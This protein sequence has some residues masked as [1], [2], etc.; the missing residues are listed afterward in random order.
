[1]FDDY[2]IEEA[3]LQELLERGVVPSL[4]VN[5]KMESS[6]AYRRCDKIRFDPLYK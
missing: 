1:V 4:V 3:Q 2:P 6:E 5:L